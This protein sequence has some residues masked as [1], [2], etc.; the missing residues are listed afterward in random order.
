MY[1]FNM[2]ENFNLLTQQM[3]ETPPKNTTMVSI[4]YFFHIPITSFPIFLFHNLEDFIFQQKVLQPHIT[5]IKL[6]C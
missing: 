3:H 1:L 6:P 5:L 4:S 2:V